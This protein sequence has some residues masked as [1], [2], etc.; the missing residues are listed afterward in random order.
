L[1]VAQEQ[2]Q[3]VALVLVQAVG[4]LVRLVQLVL[5]LGLGQQEQPSA[6]V[7]QVTALPQVRH[8]INQQE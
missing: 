2:G 8:R 3:L 1:E 7:E 4:L 5:V 6:L